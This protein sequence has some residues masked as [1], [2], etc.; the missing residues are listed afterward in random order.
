M[1]VITHQPI[2]NEWFYLLAIAALIGLATYIWQ[3]RSMPG[4]KKQA[5][6]QVAKAGWLFCLIMIGDVAD[7]PDKLLW[8]ALVLIPSMLSAFFGFEFVLEIS[9]QQNKI[10]P[11][12]RYI[13]TMI[14]ACLV[15]GMLSNS[16]HGLFVQTGWLEGSTLK[17]VAGPGRTVMITI[18]YL[19]V[20]LA[21][22]LSIRWI[23]VSDGLRRKQAWWFTLA[24]LFSPIVTV[25]SLIPAFRDMAPLPVGFLL[26]GIFIS[27]GFYR[28]HLYN[29][30]SLAQETAVRNM[31][32]G[33]LVVDEEGFIVDMN[34]AA[35]TI[36]AGLSVAV[37]RSCA[38]FAAAWPEL[39]QAVNT[40]GQQAVEVVK[41]SVEE[42]RYYQLTVTG[43]QS[44]GYCLGKIL[45]LKDITQ[46]KQDQATMLD[47]QKALSILTER[48]RLSREIH[49]T[50]GQF[51]GYA[52]AQTQAIALLLKQNRLAEALAQLEQLKYAADAAFI[53]ARESITSLKTVAET[54]FFQ[55]LQ[56]WLLQFQKISGIAVTY[57]G[58][59][60]IP[61][62]WVLAAA[63]V[64]LLRMIQ[65]ALTNARKHS[66][67]G[68]IEVMFTFDDARVKVTIADNGQGFDQQ[69]SQNQPITFGLTILK[70]RATEIAG[71]CSVESIPGQGTVVTV[72]VPLV[73]T[74]MAA[75]IQ[76]GE[77]S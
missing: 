39:A 11:G 51:P 35:R 13:L 73:A 66:G 44:S 59:E 52:K 10:V 31:V 53:D 32:E 3:F 9:K 1:S 75:G 71:V 38:E 23:L 63:E 45:V 77:L 48:N 58:P 43:L 19:F 28:W 72:E 20:A 25:L 22:A 57:T 4:A 27:W 29:T 37:D 60:A 55:S 40:A 24:S 6:I 69:T 7:V 50:Q 67:A 8:A 15:F 62:R 14:V 18:N 61:S 76:E 64:Q 42:T 2:I 56:L 5:Y 33:L 49:D 41:N 70:E 34:D 46:Q 65:E 26:T 16:W 54:D 68:S 17:V 21:T 47:Q 74:D 12:V 36:C 30:L